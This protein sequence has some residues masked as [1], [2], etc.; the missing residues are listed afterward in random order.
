MEDIFVPIAIFYA[1]YRIVKEF[2]DFFLKKKI[3]NNGHFEKAEILGNANL[4]SDNTEMQKYPS[5]KWGLVFLFTG[6]GMVISAFLY[7]YY[8]AAELPRFFRETLVMGVLLV[9]ISLGFLVY[10]L[11]VMNSKRK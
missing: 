10:F 4:L 7:Y 6:I 11:I 9:S 8:E 3:I 1:M 2:L 5:L